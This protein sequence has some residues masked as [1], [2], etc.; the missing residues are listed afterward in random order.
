MLYKIEDIDGT[1]DNSGIPL[2][3]ADICNADSFI[4][5]S[6]VSIIMLVWKMNYFQL[7][8]SFILPN[9]PSIIS[10]E[11]TGLIR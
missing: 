1:V 3:K 4:N 11:N 5:D 7:D 2:N 9:N 6:R 8:G 10:N